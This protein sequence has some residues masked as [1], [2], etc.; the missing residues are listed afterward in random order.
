MLVG[1]FTYWGEIAVPYLCAAP[2]SAMG[3]SART[4]PCPSLIIR[5]LGVED[6]EAYRAFRLEALRAAPTAFTSSFDEEDAKPLLATV[7]RL[8]ADAVVGAYD[9]SGAL[10]GCAGLTVPGRRQERHK[11]TLFGMAVAPHVTGRG[12]G[13]ALVMAV[14]GRAADVGVLQVGLTVTEGN[15]LACRL[16]RSC[17]FTVWGRE[18]RAVIVAGQAVAKL[19]MVCILDHAGP[20][21]IADAGIAS[22]VNRADSS[23]WGTVTRRMA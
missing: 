2:G 11:A 16:Y 20:E 19:H 4:V 8:T 14:L 13:K 21:I 12:V 3:D 23:T 5:R 6:A 9:A 18:P 7:M 22:L 15:L 10:L 1:T 17:G